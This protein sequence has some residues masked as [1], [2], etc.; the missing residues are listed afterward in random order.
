[1]IQ[2]LKFEY[3][4]G[5]SLESSKIIRVHKRLPDPDCLTNVLSLNFNI[6]SKEC[7]RSATQQFMQNVIHM[8]AKTQKRTKHV[9][10]FPRNCS[11]IGL[12]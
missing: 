3:H 2:P 10:N 1:M 4:V 12:H 7:V 11:S 6:A 9:L 8:L 5:N